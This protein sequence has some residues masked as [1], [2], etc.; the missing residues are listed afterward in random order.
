[1]RTAKKPAFSRKPLFAAMIFALSAP[2]AFALTPPSSSAL[3]GNGTAVYGTVTAAITGSTATVTVGSGS[4]YTNGN[5]G[6]VF[7]APYNGLGFPDAVINGNSGNTYVTDGMPTVYFMRS[8][9]TAAYGEEL[10]PSD[11]FTND[12]GQLQEM[13]TFLNLY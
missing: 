5:A 3:P 11:V 4:L 13:Q 6:V 2:A 1:M 7:A 12:N 10:L 8:V 9:P